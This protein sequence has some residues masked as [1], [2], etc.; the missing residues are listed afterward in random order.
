MRNAY[1]FG[2]VIHFLGGWGRS[3]A[4]WFLQGSSGVLWV[5][6]LQELILG[7]ACAPLGS[8]GPPFL[9]KM[10]AFPAATAP[11]TSQTT[12][13]VRSFGP[14]GA[15]AEKVF[16]WRLF[17]AYFNN[18]VLSQWFQYTFEDGAT[19]NGRNANESR[20]FSHC[21]YRFSC[22][23]EHTFQTNDVFPNG[24]SARSTC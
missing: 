23:F 5:I 12:V 2:P 19:N 21:K 3:V 17:Y 4:A 16:L 6:F 14:L 13:F 22:G 9:L 1:F 11:L 18:S 7:A 15:Q 24:L 10:Y 8:P 20:C